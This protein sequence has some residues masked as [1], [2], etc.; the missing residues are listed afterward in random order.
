[1]TT[2]DFNQLMAT[3][4]SMTVTGIVMVV[5]MALTMRSIV[6]RQ[7]AM[8]RESRHDYLTRTAYTSRWR[9]PAA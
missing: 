7:R 5:L 3:P 6:K 9:N 1:M 2:T 8:V 4:L